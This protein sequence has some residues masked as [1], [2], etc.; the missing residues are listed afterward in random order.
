M[1]FN[2]ESG[3]SGSSWL[4]TLD[5]RAIAASVALKG[6][7]PDAPVNGLERSAL[8]AQAAHDH[9]VVWLNAPA[10]YGKTILMSDYARTAEREGKPVIWL[11]LDNRDAPADAFLRHFL[12]ASEL[13]LPGVATDA[14]AHWHETRRRGQ[15]DTEQVLLLWLQ[16]LATFERPLLLCFDDVHV[17][18]SSDSFQVLNLMIEQVQAD[19]TIILASRFI[20]V[21]LG[22]LQLNPSLCWLRSGELAFTDDDVQRLLQQHEVEA[23]PRLVPGLMQRLQGWPAGLAIWLLCYRAAGRP[24][25]PAPALGQQ[26]MNDYLLGET[27]HRLDVPLQTFIRQAAVLGTFS[28]ALLASVTGDAGY[29][30]PLQ[31]ALR[32][33]LFIDALP[34]HPGWFR[35][36]PVMAGLLASDIP[37]HERQALHRRAFDWLSVHQ[38]PV[39]ALYHARCAGLGREILG[40]VEQE[41]ETILAD[42]DIAGLLDWFG[43]L[44]SELLHQSPRL[45]AIASWAWLLTHQRDKAEGMI[46][47]L[48]A[49][50]V[51]PDYEEAALLGYLDRARGQLTAAQEHCRRA[52]EQLP[53][54]RFTLRILMS[55]TLAHL[56]LAAQDPDGARIWNRLAQDLARQF[57]APAMEALALFD[58]AR[59]EFNRG[60]LGHCSVLTD[61]GLALLADGARQAERLP[62]GRL[63]LYRAVML[64]LREGYTDTL[65]ELLQQGIAAAASVH[66]VCVCYGYAVAAIGQVE[67]GNFSRALE[68]V[69]LAERLMQR[70]QVDPDSY[71]WLAL[72]KANIWISQGKVA[73]AQSTLDRL[74]GGRPYQ[75][76]PRPELF[77]MLP[78]FTALT[79]A[80]LYLASG[81]ASDSLQVADSALRQAPGTL[82]TL[83]LQLARAAAQRM[84]SAGSD[85]QAAAHLLHLLRREGVGNHL[86]SWIPAFQVPGDELPAEVADAAVNLSERELEVLRKI[87]QGHSNQEIADQ[88]FISLH[89]VKTHA[90]KIN[91]KLAARSRTQAIR[92]AQELNLL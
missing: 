16:E 83:L 53:Q 74:L 81:R 60:H 46:Q 17:L 15:V 91:V 86:L 43:Q 40:W 55:S 31:R 44:D 30:E 51:L 90:R 9:R 14:L 59:I 62:R 79:Q 67:Q 78:G 70:W 20:P 71:Q 38:E 92:R 54:E 75:Q 12:E 68:N 77:P 6:R 63:L 1:A 29:H 37:V 89:T 45:M 72:V 85:T 11:T 4:E 65:E 23:A 66:D 8:L 57:R 5:Q 80:R 35:V 39:A 84:L 87:A 10:G 88:L 18:Y 47:R 41:A 7:R 61:H 76:L 24:L 82:A 19:V 49:R 28:E 22:R 69:G 73:R 2:S 64:W 58:Y 36:H 25:E 32:L 33:N 26:E 56:C 52:L 34:H 13:Q 21:S 50:R 27:L 42:L 3:T 48:L